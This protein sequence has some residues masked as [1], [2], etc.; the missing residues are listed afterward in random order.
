MS[1]IIAP[2]LSS[3]TDYSNYSLVPQNNVDDADTV[4]ELFNKETIKRNPS[5]NTNTVVP[6]KYR[7]PTD[8]STQKRELQCWTTTNKNR[9]TRKCYTCFPKRLAKEHTISE[10]VDNSVKFHFD[11]CNRPIILATPFKHVNTLSDFETNDEIANFFKSLSQFCKFWN[12][13]DYQIS[14]NHG[15]WQHHSHLHVK[16]KGNEDLIF[17]MRQDHFKLIKMQKE[18]AAVS[19]A[20]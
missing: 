2:G 5:D 14:I 10:D 11:L 9:G 13:K 1:T 3:G 19:N 16:I 6:E 12:I 4:T 18:R 15:D 7:N 8:V 20:I 17:K